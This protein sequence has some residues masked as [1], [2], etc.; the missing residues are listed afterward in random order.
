LEVEGVAELV[1]LGLL[2]PLVAWS[3]VGRFVLAEPVLL[4]LVKN[5]IE[6]LLADLP[7]GP[8]GQLPAV[9]PGP[10][11]AGLLE[12]AGHLPE[13]LHHPVGL[14]AQK[15]AELFGIHFVQAPALLGGPKLLLEPVEGLQFLH[16]PHRLLQAEG[17]IPP[18]GVAVAQVVAGHQVLQVG[19]Q[20]RQLLPKPFVLEDRL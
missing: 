2:G 5:I 16:E 3:P 18:E 13:G 12:E 9:A 4:N 10:D 11:V 1:R 17:L 15:L 8:G 20:G 19:G 6:G 7:H 14:L